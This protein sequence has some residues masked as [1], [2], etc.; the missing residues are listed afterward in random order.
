M[1]IY[2]RSPQKSGRVWSSVWVALLATA[3]VLLNSA[4]DVH[5]EELCM[6]AM[7]LVVSVQ[8][9]VEVRR[10]KQMNWQRAT[11]NVALCPG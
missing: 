10:A 8:G 9:G 2:S 5:A 4:F 1:Q 11:L 3:V 6:P 7:A